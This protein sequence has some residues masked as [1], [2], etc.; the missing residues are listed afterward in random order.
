MNKVE[1]IKKKRQQSDPKNEEMQTEES[2]FRIFSF[3]DVFEAFFFTNPATWRV[4]EGFC[5]L[6][7]LGF[8]KN[9]SFKRDRGSDIATECFRPYLK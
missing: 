3:S 6:P 7:E 1:A 5:Q 2:L 4:L 9:L 8:L